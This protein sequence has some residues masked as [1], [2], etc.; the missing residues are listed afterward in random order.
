MPRSLFYFLSFLGHLLLVVGYIHTDT[1]HPTA[2]TP[3]VIEPLTPTKDNV[4]TDK[5]GDNSNAL[6]KSS[7]NTPNTPSATPTNQSANTEASKT[8]SSTVTPSATSS[9]MQTTT[10]TKAVTTTSNSGTPSDSHTGQAQ[11][12]AAKATLQNV[13]RSCSKQASQFKLVGGKF[14]ITATVNTTGKA[15]AVTFAKSSDK[16]MNDEIHKIAMAM[17]FTP[18]LDEQGQPT[19]GQATFIINHADCR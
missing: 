8:T 13:Q 9:L 7:A 6:P 14:K 18:A 11:N 15:S 16:M 4:T 19:T 2:T 12:R 17:T 5:T 3:I 10:T 1:P